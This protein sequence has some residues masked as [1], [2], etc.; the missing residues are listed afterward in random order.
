MKQVNTSQKTYGKSTRKL[1]KKLCPTACKS[2][3]VG[4]D[5]IVKDAAGKTVFTWHKQSFKNGLIV[6]N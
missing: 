6:I 1:I 2:V 4:N 5:V 3:K